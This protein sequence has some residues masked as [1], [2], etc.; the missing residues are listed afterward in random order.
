L[1][2]REQK[3]V[4]KS[5]HL[6]FGS[7]L[8]F[9]WGLFVFFWM[10]RAPKAL[11]T[12]LGFRYETET[13]IL[14]AGVRWFARL[15]FF[16]LLSSILMVGVPTRVSAIPFYPLLALAVSIGISIRYLRQPKP[17]EQAARQA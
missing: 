15:A 13:G 5:L 8:V 1:R 7:Y 11:M 4:D 10:A 12:L 3:P 14:V 16:S 6:G 9:T 17:D 2:W